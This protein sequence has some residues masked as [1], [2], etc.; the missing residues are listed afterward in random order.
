MATRKNPPSKHPQKLHGL[1]AITPFN[2]AH[3]LPVSTLIEQVRLAIDGGV[4][5]LQFRDKSP[6]E[7]SRLDKARALKSLCGDNAVTLL[8]NDDVALAGEVGADGVHIGA[9]DASIQ[10]AREQLGKTAIIGVSCYNQLALAQ[11]AQSAGADYVAFG[12]F[13]PS[14]SKPNAVQAELALLEQAKS[15]LQVPVACI[16]GIT[17]ENATL[18]V[19][20]GADMLAVIDGIFG[21]P[22]I[23]QAARDIAALMPGPASER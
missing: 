14:Q 10:H 3:I 1:Y 9:D 22:D 16:G 18:L 7:K 6:D 17:A 13:F 2:S 8:I 12:R 21:Q 19:R 5:L 23:R 11:Q 15:T 20:R 4:R